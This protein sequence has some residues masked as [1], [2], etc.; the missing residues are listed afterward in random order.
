MEISKTHRYDRHMTEEVADNKSDY[1]SLVR[2]CHILMEHRHP[3]G[4]PHPHLP[5]RLGRKTNKL[6]KS[7]NSHTVSGELRS[8]SDTL[9]SHHGSRYYPGALK[10]SPV[11]SHCHTV[12]S[13]PASLTK[14]IRLMVNSMNCINRK[15][16]TVRYDTT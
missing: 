1:Y 11:L 16:G 4:L 3:A 10:T 9:K 14:S 15:Q 2:T 7:S 13:Y 5:P 8:S 6:I 12:T